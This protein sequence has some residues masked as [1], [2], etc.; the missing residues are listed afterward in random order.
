[1]A[2]L[3]KGLIVWHMGKGDRCE[4]AVDCMVKGDTVGRES[5]RVKEDKD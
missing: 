2:T 4:Q 3:G 1:M 5:I